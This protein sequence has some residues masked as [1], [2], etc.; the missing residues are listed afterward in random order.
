MFHYLILDSVTMKNRMLDPTRD[1]PVN[2][3]IGMLDIVAVMI[4]ARQHHL[5][6]SEQHGAG[7]QFITHPVKGKAAMQN[8]QMC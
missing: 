1:L 6:R 2:T 7:I 8:R 3:C 5:I 4:L